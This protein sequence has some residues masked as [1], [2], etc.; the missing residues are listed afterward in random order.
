MK[1]CFIRLC[2][3]IIVSLFMY[4]SYTAELAAAPVESDKLELL[5]KEFDD[6]T[7]IQEQPAWMEQQENYSLIDAAGNE[8]AYVSSVGQDT[9]GMLNLLLIRIENSSSY[10]YKNEYRKKIE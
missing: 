9:Q 3:G 7:I 1:R 8:I 4:T 10:L 2:C 6:R 5:I